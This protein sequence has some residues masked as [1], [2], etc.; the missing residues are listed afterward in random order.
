MSPQNEK[1]ERAL[2]KARF[3]SKRFSRSRKFESK[4]VLLKEIKR[5]KRFGQEIGVLLME[6]KDPQRSGF[7]KLLPG[8][9]LSVEQM[10]QN[11]RAY[12][13]VERSGRRLYTI[14]LPQTDAQGVEAVKK[15][16]IR[17]AEEAGAQKIHVGTAVYPEHGED[18]EALLEK[19]KLELDKSKKRDR[20]TFEPRLSEDEFKKTI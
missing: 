11:L 13:N 14:L 16:V 15:K 19:A 1:D 6:V 9:P 12:D 5:A 7:H 3:K 17:L 8:I 10:G 18:A 4:N 2:K 20:E